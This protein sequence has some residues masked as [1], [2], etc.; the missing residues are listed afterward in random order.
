MRNTRARLVCRSWVENV[1]IEM[2]NFKSH[3]QISAAFNV[4]TKIINAVPLN[5][6]DPRKVARHHFEFG[7]DVS[8]MST[9]ICPADLHSLAVGLVTLTSSN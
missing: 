6:L 4:D 3:V 9:T 7:N 8:L 5:G 1:T 2:T